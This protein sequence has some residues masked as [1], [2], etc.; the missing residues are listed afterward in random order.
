MPLTLMD[1]LTHMIA[2]GCRIAVRDLVCRMAVERMV[3]RSG[4]C[5]QQKG[6][7]IWVVMASRKQA[8]GGVV[9][10]FEFRLL[11]LSSSR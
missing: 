2:R 11:Q 4:E 9:I 3:M 6:K 1:V 10:Q 8:E 5:V 7:K